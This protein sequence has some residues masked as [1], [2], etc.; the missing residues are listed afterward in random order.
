[1]W[2]IMGSVN[3]HDEWFKA[4]TGGDSGRAAA[5]AAGIPVATLNRQLG[6]GE[7][8][9]GHVIALARAYDQPPAEAL[10][11]TGYL[12]PAEAGGRAD[13]LRLA[14]DQ[15]LIREL[16]HRIDA[17]EKAWSGTFD[18]VIAGAVTP[19][20]PAC[21]TPPPRLAVADSSPDE[22]EDGTDFD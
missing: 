9:A 20:R 7:I 3:K 16:A 22:P 13:A 1:M 19:I 5:L 10:A 18:D 17:N 6:R 2:R 11:A 15:A 8:D 12:T 21:D 4:V 14:S